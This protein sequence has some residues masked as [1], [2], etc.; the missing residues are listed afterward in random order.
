MTLV[1]HLRELRSRLIKCVLAVLIGSMVMWFMYDRALIGPLYDTFQEACPPDVQCRVITTDPLQGFTTR[2]TVAGYG[3]VV[4]AMPVLLWQL[5]RFVTPGLYPKEK[6]LAVPFTIS[7]VLLF[8]LG[9]ACAWWTTP[10]ALNWLIEIGGPNTD[11]LYTPDKFVSFIT[12]MSVGFGIGF[13]FPILLVFLELAGIITWRKLLSWQ[14]HAVVGIVAIVAIIT[15]S[16]DPFTLAALSVPM[17]FFYYV[18]ILVGWLFAR[19]K[20]KRERQDA[21]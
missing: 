5:W 18:A 13:E 9:V 4:L 3:G 8:L 2:L 20:R 14:R 15:P 10:K 17:V 11:A 7:G 1:E 21:S 6:R 19:S 12:K 16:G